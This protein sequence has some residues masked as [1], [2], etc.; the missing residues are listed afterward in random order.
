MYSVPKFKFDTAVSEIVPLNVPLSHDCLVAVPETVVP[1]NFV[2]LTVHD[3]SVITT[4]T[5]PEGVKTA[6]SVYA[7][8]RDDV[9]H[10]WGLRTISAPNELVQYA[11][12][13]DSTQY[14]YAK[15]Q[16]DPG[17]TYP[18]AV[19]PSLVLK[20]VLISE[21]SFVIVSS[22]GVVKLIALGTVDSAGIA[23]LMTILFVLY[24][25]N[26]A[27]ENNEFTTVNV[28]PFRGSEATAVVKLPVAQSYGL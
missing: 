1:A 23:H 18:K 15:E 26:A 9:E 27:A 16:V 21:K 6:P 10:D 12:T 13:P 8:A 7:A 25:L 11:A 28:Y 5:V 19:V 24:V 2:K 14:S 22:P 17:G 20:A 4:A 3:W